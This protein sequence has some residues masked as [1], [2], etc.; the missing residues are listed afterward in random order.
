MSAYH[1]VK[2]EHPTR[3]AADHSMNDPEST[4]GSGQ[5]DGEAAGGHL[6]GKP[7]ML[8]IDYGGGHGGGSG[9]NEQQEAIADD[10]AFCFGSSCARFRSKSV[11][12]SKSRKS[13]TG[14]ARGRS[15]VVC[16]AVR[17]KGGYNPSDEH[18]ESLAR[19]PARRPSSSCW[20]CSLSLRVS[21]LPLTAS[22]W[23]PAPLP[24]AVSV[25]ISGL[26]AV[27]YALTG[28]S[29]RS[30]WWMGT[31]PICI[32]QFITMGLLSRWFPDAPHPLQ[33]TLRKQRA[34]KAG[35]CSMAG[36]D[37]FYL[38]WL[39]GFV[40]VSITESRRHIRAQMEKATLESEM[41]AAREVQRL[42]V[43]EDCTDQWLFHRKRLSSCFGVGGDF[44]Q[45]ILSRADAP[46]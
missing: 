24:F 33:L 30:R 9:E 34:C 20:P 4:R 37:R 45:V 41:A 21:G 5:D 32:V 23:A 46:L 38:P 15:T 17:P 7:V 42:M 6:S 16:L 43:P 25:V 11:V 44:F 14:A 26:F 39:H 3:S 18:P 31:I 19:Y 22:T 1:H 35:F 29:L 8:R 12:C 10:G 2:T 28:I 36:Y 13:S 40:Y 27:A